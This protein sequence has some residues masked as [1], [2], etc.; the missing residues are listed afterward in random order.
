[1]N[2][3]V[4]PL[5][6]AG[7]SFVSS[8]ENSPASDIIVNWEDKLI[9]LNAKLISCMLEIESKKGFNILATTKSWPK[10]KNF[11]SKKETIKEIFGDLILGDL[12][13]NLLSLER[14]LL[15]I[16]LTSNVI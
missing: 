10:G 6:Y 4:V 16:F 3:D 8:K 9:P 15:H 2:D 14:K 7:M 5:F 12:D 11:K 13:N 1:M